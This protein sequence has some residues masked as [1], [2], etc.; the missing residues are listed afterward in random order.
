MQQ[1]VQGTSS[2]LERNIT[3]SIPVE[4]LHVFDP[5]TELNL[6]ASG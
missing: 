3:V 5:E 1:A 2:P 4:K 6:T